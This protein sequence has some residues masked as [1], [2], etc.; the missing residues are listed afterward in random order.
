MTK[1]GIVIFPGTSVPYFC[2]NIKRS[3]RAKGFFFPLGFTVTSVGTTVFIY[4]IQYV[5]ISQIQTQKEARK[6]PNEYTIKLTIILTLNYI[7]GII[8]ALLK[9]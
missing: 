4:Y 1:G 9:T 8:Y 7:M 5:P 3:I 6:L 2:Q